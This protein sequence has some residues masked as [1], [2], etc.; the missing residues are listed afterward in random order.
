MAYKILANYEKEQTLFTEFVASNSGPNILLF[1]GES[2]CG[3]SH[4]VEHC[5]STV[6][7]M[8]SHFM[9]IQSGRDSIAS[10][11]TNM[12][13]RRGWENLPHFTQTV[14]NLVERPAEIDDAVWSAGMHRHLREVGKIGDLESRLSRF[15]LLSDA[16]FADALQFDTPFLLAID[17]YENVTTLFDL[18]F[19]QD[20]LIGV[21]NS[22]QMRVM[23]SGQKLPEMQ[24]EWSFCASIQELKGVHE[25]DTW[26][27]WAEEMGYQIPSLEVLSG[28]VMA[29]DG[30]PSQIIEVIQANFPKRRGPISAKDSIRTQRKRLRENMIAF[31]SL[32]ELKDICF[33][34]EI[35][36]EI[37]PDHDNKPGF[38]RELLGFTGRIGRL[39]E[40]V[41]V[42]QAERPSIEW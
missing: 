15:Q 21:A 33:D 25:A 31:F 16:W 13:R 24:D 12:G 5:L 10:L 32:S 35:D 41:Q 42:C 28:I 39:N 11:F 29:L 40:L 22:G 3:K 34:M 36:Y 17:V 30:N 23:V 2:G 1:R 37:L 8:P 19:S 38:V 26:M 7:D 27:V 14:A 4:L 9:K 20:F 6:P 18:W